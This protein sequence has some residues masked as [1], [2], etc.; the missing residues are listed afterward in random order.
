VP[1]EA[2]TATLEAI[3]AYGARSSEALIFWG[4]MTGPGVA[5]VTGVYLPG[6]DAHGACAALRPDERRWL[7]QELARRDEKLLVQVHS[8]PA[9]AFHS[10]GDDEGA[11]SF[12]EGFLSLVVPRYGR[13]VSHVRQCALFE[14][15][16]GSFNPVSPGT[17]AA[18]FILEPLIA[19][20]SGP[21]SGGGG[22]VTRQ[23]RIP[24]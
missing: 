1:L 17:A 13:G 3:R 22:L 23:G 8:H 10:D 4:G 24:R 5:S 2:W 16:R 6:H 9:D 19:H 15:S 14:F 21:A 7:V 11:A 18:R 12:H 20:R